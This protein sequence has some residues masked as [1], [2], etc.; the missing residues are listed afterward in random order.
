MDKKLVI[1]IDEA[2]M[3]PVFGPLVISGV[4]VRKDKLD[5]LTELGVKDSKKFGSGLR[6]HQRRKSVWKNA[7]DYIINKKQVV[8]DASSLDKENMYTL[9][10]K[11][12]AKILE[13]LN[14]HQVGEVYIEQL[15]MLSRDKFIRKLGFWHR[16]FIYESKADERYPSVSLA[17]IKAKLLRDRKVS[18]LCKKAGHEYVSGYANSKTE[19]FFKKHFKKHGRLPHGTRF[20][21]NW[22]PI[23]KMKSFN[24][25]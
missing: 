24:K 22:A 3:G 19:L 7:A 2:G 16:G 1:G 6:A 21:R 14:W 12:T 23:L 4:L 8:V 25:I 5:T 13:A 18:K 11:A 15:G 20:S 10:I 17:S 9:H